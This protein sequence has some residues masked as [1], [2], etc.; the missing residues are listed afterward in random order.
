MKNLT[1]CAR[2]AV[3]LV[4]SLAVRHHEHMQ[5][6]L[7]PVISGVLA[8]VGVLVGAWLGSRRDKSNWVR[9]AQL[10]ACSRLIEE[11]TRMYIGLSSFRRGVS[12]QLNW[13]SWDQALSAVCLI[14][15][16]SVVRACLT[17]RASCSR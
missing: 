3:G 11:Y 2:R 16:A 8:L 12:P 13:E 14:C 10:A 7:I 15:N 9:D 6:L 4:S 17:W 5:S 1:T